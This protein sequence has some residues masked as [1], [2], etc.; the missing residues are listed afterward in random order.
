MT[1]TLNSSTG[2]YTVA[3]NA[4]IDHAS[5]LDENNQE[6][7]VSYQVT[8]GDGDTATN[9]FTINV[10][11][12][13][14]VKASFGD[15]NIDGTIS[16]IAPN[17]IQTYTPNLL[18]W[19]LGADGFGSVNL[20]P[21]NGNVTVSSVSDNVI[22]L[23]LNDSTGQSIA[24]LQLV[25]NGN[26]SL[27]VLQRPGT[28]QTDTL[29][30]GDVTASGPSLTK[31]INSSISGLVV[32]VTAT[33]GSNLVNPST[34]GWAVNDNQADAAEA[35]TFS[36]NQPVD[37]FSFAT[38]GFTGNPSGGTVGIQVT[39]GYV[40]GGTGSF[41]VQSTDGQ[42][43]NVDQLPGFTPN[44]L[45]TFVSVLSISGGVGQDGNDGFRLNNVS[46][47]KVTVTDPGDL[48]YSFALNVDDG[49]GDMVSQ[50][51]A[52][53]LRGSSSEPFS[54]GPVSIDLNGD[55]V[56]QYLDADQGVGAALALDSDHSLGL[57]TSWVAPTD[58]L[59]VYDYNN[60]R[61]VTEARE[62]VFTMWGNDPNVATDMQALAAY[63]DGDANGAKDG[64]LDANDVAWSYFGVWQDLN[65]NG[66]QEEGEFAYLADWDITN[67]ALSYN[68]IGT[69]YAAAD[70]DV[71]VYGQMAVTYTDGTTGLAEDVAFAVAPA[72][73][74]IVDPAAGDPLPVAE[75]TEQP[76]DAFIPDEVIPEEQ[77]ANAN[78]AADANLVDQFEA[79]N[80]VNDKCANSV[81]RQYENIVINDALDSS[82][83]F[84]SDNDA[85]TITESN[86]CDF[87]DKY[88]WPFETVEILS[89]LD[90]ITGGAINLI[91]NVVAGA[92][93]DSSA[94]SDAPAD[95]ITGLL[96]SGNT[97][98]AE[99]IIN[100]LQ[101][102]NAGFTSSETLP[103]FMD[104]NLKFA[105]GCV[106]GNTTATQSI[107]FAC[108]M[109][110]PPL[111]TPLPMASAEPNP[112]LV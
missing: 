47:E 32:T 80:A 97:I 41:I 28:T 38:T 52:V 20:T 103:L 17:S 60:D 83:P 76:V 91:R 7:T 19:S 57:Q 29:L 11:D 48:D 105:I 104:P 106:D 108:C 81:N 46:V 86:D 15:T 36:F 9:S 1:L 62:F 107:D 92:S 98:G 45:I 93:G 59:L 44:A 18:D 68:A 111:P 14:P 39:V 100:P 112:L 84:L 89:N 72:E 37:N 75:T 90:D 42:I 3:Q 55:G 77:M 31:T 13:T 58:G 4:A 43:T 53:S 34:Q 85:L 54:Y 40:G 78:T 102:I 109:A 95:P 50:N 66:V 8:D 65:V 110:A 2:A 56:V 12:D 27:S 63:F 82:D 69:T 5:G 33:G 99:T 67:I 16:V 30:T 23:S 25:R 94:S 51:F 24:L 101:I 22:I 87:I 70:G 64:V 49:D 6:F 61:R 88:N 71:L 26:D 79:E 73:A 74:S 21:A 96:G 10:D 35:I